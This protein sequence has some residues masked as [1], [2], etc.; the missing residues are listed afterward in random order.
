MH[1]H[2]VARSVAIRR[3]PSPLLAIVLFLGLQIAIFLTLL[4]LLTV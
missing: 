4:A 1:R 2:A 3:R